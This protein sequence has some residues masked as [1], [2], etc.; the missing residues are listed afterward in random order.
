MQRCF[1]AAVSH[2]YIRHRCQDILKQ[3]KQFAVFQLQLG[4]LLITRL[5][6]GI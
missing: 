1:T 2:I 4:V 5:Y 3:S 6:I